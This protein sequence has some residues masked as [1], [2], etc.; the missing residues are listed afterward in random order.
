MSVTVTGAAQFECC[1]FT[2]CNILTPTTFTT[3]YICLA[4]GTLGKVW[5]LSCD[6]AVSTARKVITPN[7]VY[8]PHLVLIRNLDLQT[9]GM[10]QVGH[11]GNFRVPSPV[12]LRP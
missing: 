2:T 3:S 1:Y 6:C 12:S 7:F 5:P 8:S 11:I 4:L 10:L 9:S